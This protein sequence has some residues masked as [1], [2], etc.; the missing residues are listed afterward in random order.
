MYDVSDTGRKS[1]GIR[2]V[3]PGLIIGV[4]HLFLRIDGI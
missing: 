4:I 3:F 1:F 2:P